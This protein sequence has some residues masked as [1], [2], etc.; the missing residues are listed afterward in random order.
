MDRAPAMWLNHHFLRALLGSF[1][2]P[3]S[4]YDEQAAAAVADDA[5]SLQPMVDDGVEHLSQ[6]P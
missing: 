5:N 4:Y 6:P 2:W 3:A 1:Q